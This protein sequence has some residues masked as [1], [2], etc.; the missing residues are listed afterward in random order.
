MAATLVSFAHSDHHLL[1]A[2][3]SELT[4]R[5]HQRS[6]NLDATRGLRVVEEALRALRYPSAG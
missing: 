1:R 6:D 5:L 2:A 4:D 3:R